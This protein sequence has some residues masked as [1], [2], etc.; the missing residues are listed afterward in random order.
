MEL[1]STFYMEQS[2]EAVRSAV[3]CV[4][5]VQPCGTISSHFIVRPVAW[6]SK[7]AG[8]TEVAHRAPQSVSRRFSQSL[9]ANLSV[10]KG[11]MEPRKGQVTKML[12]VLSWNAVFCLRFWENTQ[13]LLRRGN[14]SQTPS[15]C[16]LRRRS[17]VV[18]PTRTL[19]SLPLESTEPE[20]ISP[21]PST[22]VHL[23]NNTAG[24]ME[25]RIQS[26][27]IDPD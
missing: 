15:K 12:G 22:S 26:T 18:Q 13:C 19:F 25:L 9:Q 20:S 1:L 14:I 10:W 23:G 17:I 6:A 8:T 7:S 4:G 24:K 16:K 5:W 11:W 3:V 27:L 2:S 21:C